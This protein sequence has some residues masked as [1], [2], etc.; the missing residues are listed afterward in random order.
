MKSPKQI[1]ELVEQEL[2]EYRP[3]PFCQMYA[4]HAAHCIYL[5]HKGNVDAAKEGKE[6]KTTVEPSEA[7]ADVADESKAV[8]ATEELLEKMKKK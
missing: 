2:A 5:V 6:V 4:S 3:C 1:V 8:A 7:S